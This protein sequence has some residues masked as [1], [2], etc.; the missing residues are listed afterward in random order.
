MKK[1][2]TLL[3]IFITNTAFTQDYWPTY[4]DR[5]TNDANIEWA[6]W[7]VDTV[8]F[9]HVNLSEIL[10]KRYSANKI[11][12]CMPG[13]M[14]SYNPRYMHYATKCEIKLGSHCHAKMPI[15]DSLGN[16]V[17]KT[18]EVQNED[19]EFIP[20][21]YLNDSLVYNVLDIP[22]LFY[23]EN[24]KLKVYI[25]YVTTKRILSTSQGVVL[26]PI[27]HFTSSFNFKRKNT[28]S[29][30]DKI[31]FL[32]ETKKILKVDSM[33]I[34]FG[35][36]YV[37]QLYERTLVGTLLPLIYFEKP[38]IISIATNK[39]LSMK[40]LHR[41]LNH[42][43]TMQ[44]ALTD[45]TS[46]SPHETFYETE[47]SPAM[48]KEIQIDQKWYYNETKNI[49]FCNISYVVLYANRLRNKKIDNDPSPILKIVF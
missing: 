20:E 25:P 2:V 10:R 46:T 29:L 19:D 45:T 17:T 11:K 18:K 1:I 21:S 34:G 30:K 24:R 33:F 40:E 49:V 4:F 7:R 22:Q 8:H 43:D 36:Y 41:I 16:I 48:F 13:W 23:I 35:D 32:Q 37:K 42:G 26:G 6:A 44:T 38:N 28:N 15:I 39:K 27:Y 12:V 5:F 31:I 47:L 3:S 14:S 9:T